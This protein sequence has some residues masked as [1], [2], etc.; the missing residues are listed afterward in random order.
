MRPRKTR[1]LSNSSRFRGGASLVKSAS[2]SGC[3][4]TFVARARTR[5]PWAAR[6]STLSWMSWRIWSVRGSVVSPDAIVSQLPMTLS[7]A[8]WKLRLLATVLGIVKSSWDI[9]W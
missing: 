3:G 7:T 9:P 2:D 4:W 8:P 6:V 5:R 1:E